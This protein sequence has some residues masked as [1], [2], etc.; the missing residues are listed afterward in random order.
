LILIA[1]LGFSVIL[2]AP[3]CALLAVLLTDPIQVPAAYLTIF[4]EKLAG[5]H[6]AARAAAPALIFA[7]ALIRRPSWPGPPR[8]CR[9][10]HRK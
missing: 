6:I 5:F 2:F 1:Y 8:P 10:V 4:M 9:L 3:V 7:P